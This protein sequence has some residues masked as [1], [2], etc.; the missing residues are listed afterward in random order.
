MDKTRQI[1]PTQTHTQKLYRGAE[2]GDPRRAYKR[3]D[4][5]DTGLMLLPMRDPKKTKEEEE[6]EKKRH[7]EVGW[8][9]G[10]AAARVI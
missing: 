10:L 6:E 5:A 1:A 4:R 7:M 9:T 2:R 3:I 8:S